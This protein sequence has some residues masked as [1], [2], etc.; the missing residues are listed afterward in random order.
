MSRKE[1]GIS[2][3]SAERVLGHVVG[4]AVERIYDRD[5][6]IEAKAEALAALAGLIER[7]LNPPPDDGKVVELA[8]PPGLKSG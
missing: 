1:A 8:Q 7:L 3:D 4:S 6:Y 5:P 2:R